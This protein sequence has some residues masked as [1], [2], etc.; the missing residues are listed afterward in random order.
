MPEGHRHLQA[1]QEN[2]TLAHD[3]IDRDPGR[4][5]SPVLSFYSALHWVDGYLASMGIHPRNHVS[6]RGYVARVPGLETIADDYQRLE[7]RSREAR[8]E[9][10]EFTAIEA[11]LLIQGELRRIKEA[12]LALLP[13]DN[14]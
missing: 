6:R 5:W 9:L 3:L 7:S 10:A 12:I 4:S 8:Y 13:P 14:P 11:R 1:A 2:E